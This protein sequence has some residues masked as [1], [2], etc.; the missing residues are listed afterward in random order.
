MRLFARSYINCSSQK[1]WSASNHYLTFREIH[2]IF[3]STD[4]GLWCWSLGWGWLHKLTLP[5]VISDIQNTF[6]LQKLH[7][8]TF[9][10][11]YNKSKNR[12]S[13]LGVKFLK[14]QM[15]SA[16]SQS[17]AHYN[18]AHPFFACPIGSLNKIARPKNWARWN[19]SIQ[20]WCKF[21]Y[22]FPFCLDNFRESS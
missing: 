18:F 14:K 13:Y 1:G 2:A 15:F 5:R 21:W 3:L 4:T 16:A 12:R 22:F 9:Q 7:C 20:V 10:W 6:R 17:D 11:K 8:T 19:K